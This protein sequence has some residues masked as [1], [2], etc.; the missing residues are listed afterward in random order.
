MKPSR[1]LLLALIPMAMAIQSVSARAL[2]PERVELYCHRTANEEVPEN[3]L[4]SLEQAAFD[5]CNLIEIDLRRT[6]DGQIV[7]NHDGFLERLTDGTGEAEESYYGELQLLDAGEWMGERFRPM[8]IP[9]FADAL[10]L[11]RQYDVRLYLDMKTK[12]IGP[13]VLAILQREGMLQRVQ[14]GGEWEDVRKLYPAANAGESTAGV[15]PGVSAEQVRAFHQAGKAVIANFSA[16]GHEMDLDGMRSAVAAGVDA[17]NVDFPRLGADAVGRPVERKLSAL[18]A[19]ATTGESDSRVRAILQLARYCGF[20]LQ[21]EFAH[22]LLDGDDRVSRAAAL[23]LV[24]ARPRTPDSALTPALQSERADARANAA[25]ALGLLGA[26]ASTVL[27]LLHDKDPNVAQ[28]AL[29]AISRMPGD[30][31]ASLLLPLLSQGTTGDLAASAVRG[32]AALA[33]AKHQPQIAV[34]AVPEQLQRE[35]SESHLLYLDYV[36]RGK[37]QLTQSEIDRVVGDFRCQMKM[38]QAISRLRGEA[39]MQSLEELA[40]GPIEEFSLENGLVAGFELWDRIGMDPSAA[41][42]ALASSN[43]QVA[44]R[45]EWILVQ[46]GPSVLPQVRE[47]LQ[48]EDAPVRARLIRILAWQ[49]DESCLP[50]LKAMRSNNSADPNLIDWA[51]DKIESLHPKM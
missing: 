14:F 19:Q 39:A 38:V 44:D 18:A 24:A 49:G 48:N 15:E 30:V 21:G 3:T 17:I 33:L 40:F 29:L 8:R 4:E 43:G 28:Q 5:G 32:A 13:E 12:G 6:L 46:G 31:D 1:T 7:L 35:V 25:W 11:A 23:A 42:G 10:R 27:G 16:N 36:R 22:W 45:A 34:R 37:P 9:L 50:E 41:L 2:Q 51:T 26:P 47:A 20:P